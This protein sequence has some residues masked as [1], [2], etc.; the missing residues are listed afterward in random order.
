MTLQV[1]SFSGGVMARVVSGRRLGYRLQ[2]SVRLRS[3]VGP[4]GGQG[5]RWRALARLA[6]HRQPGHW[7][8]HWSIVPQRHSG[9]RCSWVGSEP[10][11]TWLT[12]TVRAAVGGPVAAWL[13]DNGY[14]T[15]AE[16]HEAQPRTRCRPSRSASARLTDAGPTDV[17]EVEH[18]SAGHAERRTAGDVRCPGPARRVA[19]V[20]VGP[21]AAGG[22]PHLLDRH[23][24]PGWPSAL[25][26]SVGGVAAGRF[27]V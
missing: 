27:L 25:P 13:P 20:V 9:R 15:S 6:M 16:I 4:R 26:A 5:S 19:A 11:R 1:S 17:P 24:P 22:G 12:S 18:G 14:G 10:D 8:G 21:A 2:H 23:H 7:R 3:V